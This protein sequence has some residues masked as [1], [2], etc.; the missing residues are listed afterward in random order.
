MSTGSGP[1][2]G[3]AVP[4]QIDSLIEAVLFK[5]SPVR[6]FAQIVQVSTPD[7]HKLVNTRG[8]AANW[9]GETAACPATA[10][11]ELYDINP[12]MGELYANPQATQQMLDDVFFDAGTWIAQEIGLAFGAAESDAFLNGSGITQP[13]GLLTVPTSSATDATRPFGTAQYL[14]TGASGAFNGTAANRLDMFQAAIYAMRPGYRQGAVWLMSPTTL[15][16]IATMKDTLGRFLVQPAIMVG[17]PQTLLGY[18]IVECEHMPEIAA[19]SLSIVFA[20]LARGY[21]I[22]DRIGTKVLVDPFS[23]KPNVGYYCTRRL[24]GAMLNSECVKLVKFA[25][26]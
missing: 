3:F 26:S 10:T 12:P 22:A 5:Q 1:D 21:L 6:R 8:W 16:I 17:Q 25:A 9:V 7:Y 14:P 4:R 2:G 23:N 18:E 11:A 13:R 15:S 24:G 19:G 20:N